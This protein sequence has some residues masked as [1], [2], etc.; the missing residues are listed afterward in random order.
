[1]SNRPP[2]TILGSLAL[3][4][5]ALAQDVPEPQPD[6]FLFAYDASASDD[7]LSGGINTTNRPTLY[8]NQPF[9]TPGGDSFVYSRSDGAQ[10]DVWEYDIASGTH[11]QI[12]RTPEN[13]YSP[14]PSPDNR[15]I[16]V[17][18]ERNRSIWQVDRADPGNPVWLLETAG[19]DEPVGYFARNH[20]S[21]DVLFW[22]RYGF[23][24]AL[25]HAG[26]QAY[27]FV[28]GH[29][30]PASPHLIPGTSEFSFVHRQTNEE[31]WIKAVDPESRAVRP[32]TPIAGTNAN[33]TWAPDGSILQIEGTQLHRWREGAEGWEVIADLAHHGLA[34]AT[35]IAV[36]PDGTRVAVVGIAAD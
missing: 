35:R 11:T 21:G 19:V 30:V 12:T 20:A 27:H 16:S 36:S 2:L 5:P 18:F 13:E 14:T 17:V 8:D 1:M 25:S 32:I 33:Y 23:N 24:V 3:A 29:A 4:T 34:S 6:I 10:T 9:F 7:A 26:E 28:S 22:S 31:V 15:T